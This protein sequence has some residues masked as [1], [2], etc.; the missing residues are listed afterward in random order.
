MHRIG[1]HY[2]ETLR[3][4]QENLDA[5]RPRSSRLGF[6]D[7]FLRMWDFYLQYCIGAF[8]ARH[9]DDVHVVLEKG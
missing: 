6:D 4:W 2:P 5:H 9:V 8:E 1:Q 7:R 3:R